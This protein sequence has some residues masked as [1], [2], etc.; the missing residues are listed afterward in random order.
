M[1]Q[2]GS[3]TLSEEAGKLKAENERLRGCIESAI[4]YFLDNDNERALFV[5][6]AALDR[7]EPGS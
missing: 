1:S 4:G 3:G 6:R 5:L 7:K 2:I